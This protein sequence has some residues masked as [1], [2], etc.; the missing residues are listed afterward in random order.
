[1]CIGAD[2]LGHFFD[3]GFRYWKASKAG[4]TKD[5]IESQGR[6]TEMSIAGL[7]ASGVYSQADLEANRKGWQFY[8]DLEANPSSLAFSIKN[9]ISYMWNEQVNPS[10]YI[11]ELGE[12]VWRNLLTGL[13]LGSIT[14]PGTPT[15]IA[16]RLDLTATNTSV[17]GTYEWPAG[18]AKANKGKITG[19]AITQVTISV[20]G[21]TPNLAGGP[22]TPA[23]A[24]PVS[25]VK[26]Q[27][28]WE[29]GS[30][31]GKGVLNSVGERRL[32]GT[33]GL[34][35]SRTDGGDLHVN[36]AG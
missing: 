28:D 10:F 13:W 11:P 14:H 20:A 21:D 27:F 1:V 4:A 18:D 22:P 6:G 3:L 33:W 12:V 23:S 32:E 30:A 8:K 25:G 29:R 17:N 34:G 9:Y 16:I 19:G 7:G 36:K 2:K 31:T 24:T 35:T 15:P 5:Q 26:I